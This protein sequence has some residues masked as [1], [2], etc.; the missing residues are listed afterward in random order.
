MGSVDKLIKAL[1]NLRVFQPDG[2]E[3]A[4]ASKYVKSNFNLDKLL[5][6]VL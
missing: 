3:G 6:Y 5:K 1:E 4:S 2:D